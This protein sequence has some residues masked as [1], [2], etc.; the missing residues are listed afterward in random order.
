MLRR[1]PLL[2]ILYLGTGIA[3]HASADTLR[4]ANGDELSGEVVEWSVDEVVLE[5]PQLGRIRLGLD[6]LRLDTGEPP[7]PGLFGTPFLR[8]WKRR[9]D[10]GLNGKQGN[11]ETTV[12]TGGARFSYDDDWS[13]WR[14]DGR[15][16]FD[17]DGGEVSDNNGTVHLRHDWLYPDTDWFW[18]LGSRYQFDEKESWRHRLTLFG[19]PG[20]NILESETQHLNVVLGPS[21]TREWGER[22]D[23][24]AEAAMS[25]DYKWSPLERVTFILSNSVFV[26][27]APDDGAIRTLTRAEWSLELSKQPAFSLNLGGE[28]EYETRPEEEDKN[29]D[30]KYYVTLGLDF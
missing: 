24:K 15:Y 5:H 28:N 3:T 1:V 20:Y 30:L 6:Q 25:F 22:D 26:E 19:G 18:S 8:G 27:L 2:G 14:L 13:R 9:I 16:F 11:S 4:L 7:N 17:R 23:D 21:F 12:I 29:N 10:L